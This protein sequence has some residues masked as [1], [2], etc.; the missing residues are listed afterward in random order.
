MTLAKVRKEA[1][2]LAKTKG[3]V[4]GWASRSDSGRD[5]RT[6]NGTYSRDV[7]D[8]GV[9]R[10][11]GGRDTGASNRSRGDVK[12]TRRASARGRAGQLDSDILG[13]RRN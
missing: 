12:P 5:D 8:D 10:Q 4:P 7:Y 13:S 6:P 1:Y 9:P 2:G 3:D 11:V